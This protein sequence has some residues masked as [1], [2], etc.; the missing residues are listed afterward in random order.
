VPIFITSSLLQTRTYIYEFAEEKRGRRT[1]IMTNTLKGN[2]PHVSSV[3]TKPQPNTR[4]MKW[5]GLDMREAS[6]E[7]RAAWGL[8]LAGC[9][10]LENTTKVQEL[11]L[12]AQADDEHHQ[13]T[14]HHGQVM[15]IIIIS[16]SF[17]LA[18]FYNHIGHE[19]HTC[20]LS[21]A[22]ELPKNDKDVMI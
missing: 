5:K 20:A 3:V 19:H 22:S 6:I 8:G 4:R 11:G 18:N 17:N 21:W 1:R 2:Q 7:A 15:S 14:A 12:A 9:S 16:S 10:T 13:S